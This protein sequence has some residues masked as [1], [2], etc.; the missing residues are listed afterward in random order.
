MF[1]LSQTITLTRKGTG[2]ATLNLQSHLFA[3][4]IHHVELILLFLSSFFF[5][6]EDPDPPV[7]ITQ[8]LLVLTI[9]V[10]TLVIIIALLGMGAYNY[11]LDLQLYSKDHFGK[12]CINGKFVYHF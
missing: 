7:D 9:T 2:C 3:K 5:T 4:Y 8:G 6:G 12:D 10:C 11:R 1:L